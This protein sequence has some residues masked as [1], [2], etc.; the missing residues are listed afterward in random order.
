[1]ESTG[2]GNGGN[3]K[4]E[5]EPS[6]GNFKRFYGPT[7]SSAMARNSRGIEGQRSTVTATNTAYAKPACMRSVEDAF[8][9]PL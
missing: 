6:S 5:K 2:T 8:E 9:T 7:E 1:M 4:I 3:E